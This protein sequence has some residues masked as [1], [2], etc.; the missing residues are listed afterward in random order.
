M[1]QT[2]ISSSYVLRIL[3][4]CI[5]EAISAP[6]VVSPCS[7]YSAWFVGVHIG[8]SYRLLPRSFGAADVI[9]R[10]RIARYSTGTSCGSLVPSDM[11]A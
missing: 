1:R 8:A 10:W 6:T 5:V 11:L 4:R 3:R 2:V 9:V 7:L